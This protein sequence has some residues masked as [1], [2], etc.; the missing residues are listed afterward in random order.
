MRILFY[1]KNLSIKFF[2]SPHTRVSRIRYPL[3]SHKSC[4]QW[5]STS[6]EACG[7]ERD[8]LFLVNSVGA[9]IMSA[10]RE[11]WTR[12]RRGK[13]AHFAML[14]LRRSGV[15][16]SIEN[17]SR[18]WV[19][20]RRGRRCPNFGIDIKVAILLVFAYVKAGLHEAS[21]ATSRMREILV[22]KVFFVSKYIKQAVCIRIRAS[23]A[24][25]SIAG[26]DVRWHDKNTAS[27]DYF[28]LGG[29]IQIRLNIIFFIFQYFSYIRLF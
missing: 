22:R 28:I 29:F 15:Y 8:A 19:L 6:S 12:R 18:R 25:W 20:R 1:H 10:R 11:S 23:I 16:P 26:I 27:I 13:G 3:S 21:E 9:R 2:V 7:W 5:N 17:L 4:Q 24:F 14:V